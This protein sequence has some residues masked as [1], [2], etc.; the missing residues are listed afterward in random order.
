MIFVKIS[1]DMPPQ[2][3]I[4]N[5]VIPIIMHLPVCLCFVSNW[6][7]LSHLIKGVNLFLKYIAGYIIKNF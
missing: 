1:D 5:M 7:V 2:I 6:S 4:L 3:N